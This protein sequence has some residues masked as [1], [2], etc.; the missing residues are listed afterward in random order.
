MNQSP[1]L[2]HRYEVTHRTEYCYDADVTSSFARARLRPRPT[3]TQQVLRH[4]VVVSPT[5]DISDEHVDFFGNY[6][7][8]IEIHTPHRILSVGQTS[9]VDVA[10]PAVDLS[11]LDLTVADAADRLARDPSLDPTERATYLLASPVI[12]LTDEV[13]AFASTMVDARCPVGEAIESVYH[14]IHERFEYSLGVTSVKTT[15]PEVIGARAG[16]CQDFAHL[17]VACF[18]AV[19][20]PAR[21]VSGYIETSAPGEPAVLTG[22]DA[23]HAWAS[24]LVPDMG[25][26]DLDPTNDHLADSRYIVTAWGRDFR[27]VSPLKG[28][29]FSSGHDSTLDVAVEVR[30]LP[31]S[32]DA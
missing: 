5:P 12:E 22:A 32:A 11:A 21:Y 29:I 19:G 1:S 20:L 24:V 16:V 2:T 25:W 9:V 17:A 26:V 4:E 8:Y 7:Q 18:R 6:S 31:D 13:R 10:W 27:D 3:P 15:L 23:T 14:S 30:R 28:V